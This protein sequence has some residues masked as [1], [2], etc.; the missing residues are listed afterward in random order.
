MLNHGFLQPKK[1]SCIHGEGVVFF[2]HS[3]PSLLCHLSTTTKTM[4]TTQVCT[5]MTM[6]I[7]NKR[8]MMI[9][10]QTSECR[11]INKRPFDKED[12]TTCGGIFFYS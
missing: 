5:M 12:A 11:S 7:Q 4:M 1:R 2:A 10:H 6:T 3:F 9:T 8:T